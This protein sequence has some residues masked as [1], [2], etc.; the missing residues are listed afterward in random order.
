MKPV[1]IGVI[2]CG[3]VG[4]GAHVPAM[5]EMPEARLVAIADADERRREKVATKYHVDAAYPEHRALLANRDVEAVIIAVPTP[6]HAEVAIAAMEAGK[7]VLCEMPLAST[8]D[9]AQRMID[10]AQ[11]QGVILMPGLNFRFT[12][13]YV[14]AKQLIESGSIGDMAALTYREWIPAAD[15][16]AQWPAGAWMW[17]IEQ[18]GGPLFTLAV[19]SIDLIRWL[20][21]GD[22][23]Q[24]HAATSYTR[25]EKTGGTLGYDAAVALRMTTGEIASLQ[26]SGSVNHESTISILEVVGNAT[27][28][29]TATNNDRVALL[30]DEPS[31]TEW[32]VKQ[33]GPRMWGHYQQD[34]HFVDC[35][36]HGKVPS[37]VPDDAIKAMIIAM[38]IAEASECIGQSGAAST[39]ALAL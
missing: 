34:A 32:N 15:L 16:A 20:T 10:V 38:Q 6:L 8:I 11:R 35:I 1:G 21:G 27:N 30:A 5:D 12:P 14:K 18:S 19:W 13:N 36:R 3:F 26:Y 37:I 29:L 31:R 2:G 7:H 22:I 24:V 25:L 28:V 9:D 23:A 17:N 39:T 4:R 33:P